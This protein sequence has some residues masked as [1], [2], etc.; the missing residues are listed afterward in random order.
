[1]NTISN[2]YFESRFC[3][4]AKRAAVWQVICDYLQPFIAPESCVLDLGAGYCSFINHVRARERHALDLFPSLGEYAHADVQT[5][6]GS[7]DNLTIFSAHYFDVVLASNLLEHLT[8]EA[9]ANTLSEVRRVLKPSGRFVVIQPNFRYC[10]R[11]YFDD[12]THLLVFTDVTLVDLLSASGFHVERV[13]PR[14]LPTSMKSRLPK[15]PWMVRLYLKSPLRPFAG[16]MLVICRPS[17]PGC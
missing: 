1:M 14:F 5:H 7:C 6:V 3:P 4:D 15:W 16:Q 9:V 17:N 2:R 12:Y 11:E 10:F 13:E 8:R